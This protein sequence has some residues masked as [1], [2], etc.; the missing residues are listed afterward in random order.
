L[1][2]RYK[3]CMKHPPQQLP[4]DAEQA[5][6]WLD[7]APATLAVIDAD[8]RLVYANRRW[9]DLFGL[10][11]LDQA[12]GP[13]L[14]DWLHIPGDFALDNAHHPEIQPKFGPA[15]CHGF[16]L[17]LQPHG[18]GALLHLAVVRQALGHAPESIDGRILS[19]LAGRIAEITTTLISRDTSIEE[20]AS[21]IFELARE[22]TGSEHGF[23]ATT[24]PRTGKSVGLTQASTLD[25]TACAL[26][27]KADLFL[28]LDNG[29]CNLWGHGNRSEAFF[30]NAPE[31][32]PVLGAL[33]PG[34]LKIT[35]FISAPARC[36][37][38]LLGQLALANPGRD[39]TPFDL[40]LVRQFADLFAI[41]VYRARSQQ[42]LQEA[43]RNAES[44]NQL[45][46]QFL[47]NMSHEL[48][49]PLN[50][51]M[52]MHQLLETTDLDEEQIDYL[53][54]AQETCQG[55]VGT[56]S[57]ILDL[58]IIEAG[59]LRL[60]ETAFEL[61]GLLRSL[62]QA[63]KGRFEQKKLGFTIT[64]DPELPPVLEGDAIRLRQILDNLITNALKFTP[65][66]GAELEAFSLPGPNDLHRLVFSLS[67]TGVGIAQEQQQQVFG[68]FIQ[69]EGSYSRRFGGLGL[70]LSIVLKLVKLMHGELEI[71]SVP[72]EG[73]EV[74][75][76]LPLALPATDF[77]ESTAHAEPAM[78]PG[79]RVL[80]V[81]D[82]AVNRYTITRTLHKLGHVCVEAVNGQQGLETLQRETFDCVL[83]DIQM[84]VLDGITATQ[85]IRAME[86]P[87]LRNTPIVALTAHAM[88]GDRE[89]FLDAGVDH[90]LSKPVRVED[91]ARVLHQVCGK[92]KQ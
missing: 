76:I 4:P 78:S 57:D 36:N 90:Y 70:G 61:K 15:S 43:L 65:Q 80:L 73:T 62:E 6:A 48:R 3:D 30:T 51:I 34:H 40:T 84:P 82:N 20:T 37:N 74:R 75:V 9:L 66:G 52:G 22:A 79:L 17:E 14:G 8:Q 59:K 12:P 67:D 92:K 32:D 35:R 5:L 68:L 38:V 39:Y 64:L 41:A 2:A 28:C 18:R 91:L 47:A 83:M 23:L 16:L 42:Q 10:T 58:S 25:G 44:A 87:R 69:A 60:E 24:D 86:D 7:A 56:I 72:N 11:R 85:R 26:Q 27:R 46:T 33:P 1:V 45:K 29:I 13:D 50:G 55:L 63:Y 21:L 77:E 81:E 53:N 88:H 71:S 31:A 54:T 89:R 49:T 19:Q